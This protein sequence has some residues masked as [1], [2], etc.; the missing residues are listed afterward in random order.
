MQP[1]SIQ[2]ADDGIAQ[3]ILADRFGEGCR[4]AELLA[5]RHVSAAAGGTE[6]HDGG[7]GQVRGAPNLFRQGEP[8][9]VGHM[10][11]GQHQPI[12]INRC[13]RGVE[14]IERLLATLHVRMVGALSDVSKH[15]EM[16]MKLTEERNLLR[17]L[18]DNL[19][20]S[21]YLKDA[22]AR[23]TLANKANVQNM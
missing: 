8:V 9:H 14:F 3:F 6:H 1:P 16:E 15:N 13:E 19:P 11:V 12:G 22:Q 18:I 2:R 10:H 7:C 5:S 20:D 4:E 23:K 17:A 21:I